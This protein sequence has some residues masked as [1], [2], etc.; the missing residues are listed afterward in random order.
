VLLCD[1]SYEARVEAE[2]PQNR[3]LKI[4]WIGEDPPETAWRTFAR[5]VS[6][7]DVVAAMDELFLP[8]TEVEFDLDLDFGGADTGPDTVPPDEVPPDPE[9]AKRA[10][11]A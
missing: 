5:P 10:L 9:P 11:I 2:S 1:Q 4:I 6:W 8:A 7:P 3:K